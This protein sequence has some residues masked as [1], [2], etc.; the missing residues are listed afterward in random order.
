MI[1][2]HDI[3]CI[4][5]LNTKGMLRNQKLAKG[6]SDVSWSSFEERLEYKADWYGRTL[7]KVDR[8]FPSSQICSNCSHQ[9]GKKPLDIRKWTCAKCHVHHDR[10]INASKNIL[11]EGLRL[12]TLE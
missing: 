9:N 6:I 12:H 1:K 3:I 2:N 11:T 10:D 5:D 7:I 8:W 4:E